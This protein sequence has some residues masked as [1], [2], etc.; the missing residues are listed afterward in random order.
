MVDFDRSRYILD[1]CW[2]DQ[3]ASMT[4]QQQSDDLCSVAAVRCIYKPDVMMLEVVPQIGQVLIEEYLSIPELA[5]KDHRFGLLNDGEVVNFPIETDGGVTLNG[6]IRLGVGD[7]ISYL[8][9]AY[10]ISS[11]QIQIKSE[12][13]IWTHEATENT[14]LKC[15]IPIFILV[16]VVLGRSVIREIFGRAPVNRDDQ[17][18]DFDYLVDKNHNATISSVNTNVIR[19]PRDVSIT[20]V[21]DESNGRVSFELPDLNAFGTRLVRGSKVR[22]TE[23]LSFVGDCTD[24]DA[25]E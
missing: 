6:D 4:G 18:D 17:D 16:C 14:I 1:I 13:F 2:N 23:F 10:G 9:R 19:R 15:V 8:N 22:S 3:F 24:A 21:N 7:F 11:G 25:E 12:E 5:M 20:R